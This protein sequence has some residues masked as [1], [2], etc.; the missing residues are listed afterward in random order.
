MLVWQLVWLASMHV[1]FATLLST[2][3]LTLHYL[4]TIALEVVWAKVS[5]FNWLIFNWIQHRWYGHSNN[6]SS[7]T[8]THKYTFTYELFMHKFFF[9]LVAI[10]YLIKFE[11][12]NNRRLTLD[13]YGNSRSMWMMMMTTMLLF[14][15]V[16][17]LLPRRRPAFVPRDVL[18]KFYQNFS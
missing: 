18:A 17:L 15:F 4:H 2:L 14:L 10:N 7:H 13:I 5:A 16:F 8:N 11:Q 1:N 9:T 3:P 6:I 12:L